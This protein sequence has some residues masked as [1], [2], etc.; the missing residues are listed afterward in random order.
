MTWSGRGAY[1]LSCRKLLLL[2][3][4][5]FERLLSD[6]KLEINLNENVRQKITLQKSLPQGSVISPI[7]FNLYPTDILK[8]TST[9][10]IL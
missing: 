8:I 5:L 6:K 1:Y 7:F 9:K 2:T 10:F 3:L 4:T